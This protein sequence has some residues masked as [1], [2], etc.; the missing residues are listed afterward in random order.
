MEWSS[1]P[2]FQWVNGFVAPLCAERD[3]AS[4]STSHVWIGTAKWI[5][6]I[7]RNAWKAEFAGAGAR[8]GDRH[9]FLGTFW[10]L[11]TFMDTLWTLM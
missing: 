1:G 3:R 7:Q 5:Q 2:P 4:I 9:I 10:G 8:C 11:V 6:S